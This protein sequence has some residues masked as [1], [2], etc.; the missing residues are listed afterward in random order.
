VHKWKD[1][2]H[3]QQRVTD[4]FQSFL[5]VQLKFKT[6][7]LLFFSEQANLWWVRSAR[8]RAE[9]EVPFRHWKTFCCGVE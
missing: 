1:E 5:E 2:T 7:N 4:V 6:K 8:G 9:R 3:V